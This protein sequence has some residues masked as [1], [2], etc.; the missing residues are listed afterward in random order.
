MQGDMHPFVSAQ[1]YIG[2]ICF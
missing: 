2:H 1:C